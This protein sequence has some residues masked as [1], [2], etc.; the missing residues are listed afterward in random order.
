MSLA[1]NSYFY[2]RRCVA[3]N[4]S[5]PVKILTYLMTDPEEMVRMD[6]AE[7]KMTSTKMLKSLAN[8]S[9]E[10]VV[11]RVAENP[12]TPA[13]ISKMLWASITDS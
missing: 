13:V 7:N 4:P 6:V 8:D 9:C 1:K 10:S 2:V 5:T 12:N 3:R 11:S